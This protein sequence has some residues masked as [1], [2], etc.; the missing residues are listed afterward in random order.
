[1]RS[2]PDL[3]R[4]GVELGPTAAQLEH[5]HPDPGTALVGYLDG[6]FQLALGEVDDRI[7]FV[8][9]VSSVL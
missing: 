2:E 1:M 9:F 4:V 7:S 6:Y 8:G 3:H 5:P